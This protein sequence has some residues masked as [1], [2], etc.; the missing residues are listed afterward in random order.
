MLPNAYDIIKDDSTFKK[1]QVHD[2]MFV[3]YHCML[4]ELKSGYWTSCNYVIYI[5]TGKKKWRSLDKGTFGHPG[6]AIFLKKGAYVAE[7]FF[8]EEFCSLVIFLPDDFI[9]K[10]L[11]T[12]QLRNKGKSVDVKSQSIFKLEV[13]PVLKS[14]FDSVW[15]YFPMQNPPP[16]TLLKV[17][18]EEF[19]IN[20]LSNTNNESLVS[21][22]EDLR[23]SSKISIP[24]IMD[25]NF[26]YNIKLEEFAKL[27]GRSLSTF[28][29]DFKKEYQTSPSKW[30]LKRRLDYAKILLETTDNTINGVAF[31]S[32]FEDTSHFIRAFKSVYGTTPLKFKQASTV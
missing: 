8:E 25:V 6:E 22:F 23:Y 11:E 24:E 4:E 13:D 15:S 16:T 14:Y 2:L 20:I 31:E 30:L 9:K 10:T 19:I 12:H 28:Q 5:L 21:Y 18:F 3:E 27:S 7:Q 26:A 1:F 17:K 29:R 32:G